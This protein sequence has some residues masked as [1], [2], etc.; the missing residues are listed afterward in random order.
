MFSENENQQKLQISYSLTHFLP[1]IAGS[2]IASKC[3]SVPG[4]PKLEFNQ[5]K[6]G[7]MIVVTEAIQGIGRSPGQCSYITGDCTEPV[8]ADTE[9]KLHEECIGKSACEITVSVAW[10][11]RCSAY[12]SYN[13]LKYNCVPREYINLYNEL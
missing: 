3:F 12:S 11:P 5:C 6:P 13:Y 4:V 10:M 2:K 9:E 7:E 8:T 1:L